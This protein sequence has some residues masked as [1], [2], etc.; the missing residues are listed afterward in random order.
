MVVADTPAT[1][2]PERCQFDPKRCSVYNRMTPFKGHAYLAFD[3]R[4]TQQELHVIDTPLIAFSA[5]AFLRVEGLEIFLLEPVTAIYTNSKLKAGIENS[6]IHTDAVPSIAR[7]NAKSIGRRGRACI[8][9]F[10]RTF[11]F[12]FL[13]K[14]WV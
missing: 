9:R 8:L 14:R 2:T 7:L 5:F 12:I 3:I 4:T 6:E 13:K 11:V 1:V 10:T